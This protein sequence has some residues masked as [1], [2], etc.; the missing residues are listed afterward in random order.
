MPSPCINVCAVEDERCI[1]CGRTRAEIA[2]WGAMTTA[3][4]RAWMDEHA[5]ADDGTS[6]DD[7]A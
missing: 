2:S 6:S 5:A 1:A 3:E 4:Q 7:A